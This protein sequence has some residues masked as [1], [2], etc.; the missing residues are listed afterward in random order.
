MV[1]IEVWN[2]SR[3]DQMVMPIQDGIYWA[4]F[5]DRAGR[6]FE[7]AYPNVPVDYLPRS[8]EKFSRIAPGNCLAA[9]YLLP[10]FYGR[11]KDPKGVECRARANTGY[12]LKPGGRADEAVFTLTSDW[13]AIPPP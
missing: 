12:P 5:R 4:E 2:L 9:S 7:P 13:I 6:R 8:L 10:G 11:V 3:T 1:R